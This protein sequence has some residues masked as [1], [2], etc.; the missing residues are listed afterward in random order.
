VPVDSWGT[1]GATMA[2]QL[3]AALGVAQ[4]FDRLYSN[5]A[6]DVPVEGIALH[7]DTVPRDM[8][9]ELES[10]RLV[11]SSIVHPGDMVT[12]E[13]TLRPWQQPAHNVRIPFRIPARLGAGTLRL[14][15][16]GSHALDLTLEGAQ[17]QTQAPTLA[18]AAARL[19]EVHAA[20]QL[21][22][23]ILVPE[24]QASLE[25]QTLAGLPLSMANTLE[26]G[27]SGGS[28]ALHGE[29]LVVTAQAP[30]GGVL[31]GQQL[32]TLRVEAGGGLH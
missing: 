1:P 2:T 9:T 18:A 21:Y 17:P 26:A 12:V 15:V 20:D 5:A 11:S 25:G 10:V 16:S 24:S 31:S 3:A 32:L 30:A 29:S 23:S 7:V 28:V 6:R 13:A 22:V 8:R 14:L 19:R 27:S 4:S